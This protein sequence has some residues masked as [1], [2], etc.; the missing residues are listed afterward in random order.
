MRGKEFILLIIQ[1]N[2][3][4]YSYFL[5]VQLSKK[6]SAAKTA[7]EA[8][9]LLDS[10]T[11]TAK[12][13]KDVND[14]N[15]ELKKKYDNDWAAWNT[16]KVNHAQ[17]NQSE[18]TRM[19]NHFT[20]EVKSTECKWYGD[21]CNSARPE[22][23]SNDHGPGWYNAGCHSCAWGNNRN[24]T[25]K[26]TSEKVDQ[27]TN[28]WARANLRDFSEA[29]PK[30]T[31]LPVMT[32]FTCCPNVAVLENST[33]TNTQIQQITQ[34][35]T[36]I[37][38]DVEKKKAEEAAAAEK[39]AAEKAAA[40]KAAADKAAADKAAADKAEAEKAAAGAAAS[41]EGLSN[42]TKLIILI[43]IVVIVLLIFWLVFW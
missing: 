3:F 4:F 28:A 2:N 19:Y 38:Q 15:V 12:T 22:W 37:K 31:P 39:A 9:A 10:C 6:M 40:D 11:E 43:V 29:E 34:C 33:V 25:C 20:N 35:I 30:Y 36:D 7:E 23:C 5:L 26:R 27:E 13:I 1:E 21:G 14:K 41:L 18:R 17:H 8:Q 32:S 16:R 42:R 24:L